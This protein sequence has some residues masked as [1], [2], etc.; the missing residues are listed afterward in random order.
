L[1]KVVDFKTGKGGGDGSAA[2]PPSDR[3]KKGGSRGS[4]KPFDHG[5]FQA[6][7]I[8]FALV[9]GTDTVI[10]VPGR[11][12][13]KIGAL[14][15]AYGNDYVKMWLASPSRRMVTPEQIV[16]DPTGNAQSPLINLFDRL[17]FEPQQGSCDKITELLFHLCGER[18][19]VFEWV[20]RWIAYQV[21]HVGAKMRTAIVMH[22]DEGSGKNLFW[23]VVL[24][25]FGQYGITIGQDQVESKYNDWMSR[26]MLVVADEVVTRSELI[27]HKGRLKSYITGTQVMIETKNLPVRRESNH[28][29]M[30]F[31]SN[32]VQ[33]LSLDDSDRRY[34][35]VRTPGKR[36]PEF[37]QAVH[38]QIQA[39]GAAAYMWHLV[40][41]VG[42]G[43]FDEH[44]K[45]LT[46][47]DK[48]N[49]IELG[50]SGPK[51]FFEDWGAGMLP[52]PCICTTM[53]LLYR[54]YIKWCED[55]GERFPPTLTRFSAE[56]ERYAAS[57][58]IEWVRSKKWITERGR[59]GSLGTDLIQRKVL[60]VGSPPPDKVERTWL[61][62]SIGIFTGGL[63][64][65]GVSQWRL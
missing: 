51:R 15:L 39:G 40:N 19:N 45:P 32:E 7:L 60:V 55:N 41:A 38:E 44:T 47:E 25:I 22:G 30:V 65:F 29:N 61:D 12:I 3:P 64:R 58:E 16:F 14:R 33:P 18:T 34:M 50:A 23:D 42:L 49:L 57:R 4:D 13:M 35:V 17:P 8:N 26:K 56:L 28:M 11:M 24:S 36:E 2:G 20:E 5:M 62:Q 10:D 59:D 54:A 48:A 43:D 27:Q 37:Y 9:Y 52:V 53:N 1:S 21:R 46:T 6:L 63:E 31:T